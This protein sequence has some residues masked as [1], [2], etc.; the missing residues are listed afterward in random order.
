MTG[1]GVLLVD[2]GNT[3]LKWASLADGH[4]GPARAVTHQASGIAAAARSAWQELPRPERILVGSV[5]GPERDAELRSLCHEL[6]GCEP[7]FASA[8]RQAAG[9]TSG[10]DSPGQLGVDRWLALL[11]VH[12]DGRGATCVVDC[13]TAVTL[14]L[15]DG[16][17]RHGG[18]LI[19]PGL[20]L[21]QDC[22]LART[23]IPPFR[24]LPACPQLG[25][26]TAAAVANGALLAVAGAVRETLGRAHAT[27]GQLPRLVIA[28]GDARTLAAALDGPIE[29]R[30]DLVLEGL[31]VLAG[32]EGT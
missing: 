9:V 24:P 11:A 26:E 4:L 7:S 6:W 5:A 30:P 3:R 16:T 15:V 21:M 18:G 1:P 29:L 27:L 17:G 23:R 32:I 22:L 2:L 28:G 8:Q 31:A 19:L 20:Q 25:R 14:D 10:Y 12:A 13:G